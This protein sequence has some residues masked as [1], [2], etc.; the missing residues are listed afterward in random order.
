MNSRPTS[1]T[2]S[3]TVKSR[4]HRVVKVFLNAIFCTSAEHHQIDARLI[5]RKVMGV[6]DVPVTVSCRLWY[7]ICVDNE[8]TRSSH[9]LWQTFHAPVHHARANQ[10]Q[11]RPPSEWTARKSYA[12]AL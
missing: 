4:L 2:A 1:V 5:S 6:I 10:S 7:L 3:W 9:H 12:G 11:H 8:R